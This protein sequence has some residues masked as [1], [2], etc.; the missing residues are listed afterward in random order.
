MLSTTVGLA[1]AGNTSDLSHLLMQSAAHSY[2]HTFPPL[3]AF[4]FSLVSSPIDSQRGKKKPPCIAAESYS[5]VWYSEP[6]CLLH[7]NACMSHT[8]DD[9]WLRARTPSPD[10][11]KGEVSRFHSESKPAEW[12]YGW[13][14]VMRLTFGLRAV[15]SPLLH[16]R[17]H[18]SYKQTSGL[19][20]FPFGSTEVNAQFCEIKLINKLV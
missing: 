3:A 13:R 2:K 15:S 5:G 9:G 6:V 20:N 19:M 8:Q 16:S 4:P 11:I 7:P 10:L 1:I 18:H 14:L 12:K 17:N